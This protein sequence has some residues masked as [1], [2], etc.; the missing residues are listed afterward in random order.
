MNNT[1]KITYNLCGGVC[2][3]PTAYSEDDSF[4]LGVPLR[5]GYRFLGWTSTD[6]PAPQK[7]VALPKGSRGDREYT[8][9][10]E[11]KDRLISD[12][13]IGADDRL[14]PPDSPV[15]LD[16]RKGDRGENI[17]KLKTV[18]T[19][20]EVDGIKDAA[21]DYG[22]HIKSGVYECPEYYKDK[23]IGFDA[24]LTLGQDGYVYVFVEVTDPNV[25]VPDELWHHKNWRCD[26]ICMFLS[27]DNKPV[28]VGV[29]C[30]YAADGRRANTVSDKHAAVRTEKGYNIEFRFNN[31]GSPFV[32]YSG[33]C[34][35]C[36]GI[37]IYMNDCVYFESLD[38]YKKYSITAASALINDG[39]FRSPHGSLMDAVE[40]SYESATGRAMGG[41]AEVF[42]EGECLISSMLSSNSDNAVV[43]SENASVH[44]KDCIRR[45]IC[46][47][48]TVCPRFTT[49]DDRGETADARILFGLTG[50]KESRELVESI[51]YGKCALVFSNGRICVIG[52]TEEAME[53]AT[54]LL[55]AAFEYVSEGGRSDDLCNRYICETDSV[56]V[57]KADGVGVITDAGSGSYLLLCR[58]ADVSAYEKYTEKL[59]D[60]GYSLYA[61]RKFLGSF[62]STYCSDGA[63]VNV[64]FGGEGDRNLRIVAD[65]RKK[66]GLPPVKEQYQARCRPRLIQIGHNSMCYIVKLENGEFIIFD[67]GNNGAEVGIYDTLISQSDDGHPVVAA[68]FFTH[69]HQDHIGGFIDF[70]LKDEYLSRVTVKNVVMNMPAGQVISTSR[71]SPR[72]MMNIELWQSCLERTGC[73]VI[74]PRTGQRFDFGGA[75]IDVLFTFEDVMP[76]F[77]TNDQSNITST[78]FSVNVGGQRIIITGDCEREGT[79]LMADKYRE[80]LKCDF[81]Q[82]PH[83]GYGS[84]GGTVPEFYEY[85]GADYVLYPDERFA[86][87]PTEKVGVDMAKKCFLAGDGTVILDLPFNE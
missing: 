45:F 81:V 64:T 13:N 19:D 69:Y 22:L 65:S 12:P 35:S 30:L 37:A 71:G 31:N 29:G 87:Q 74:F 18:Y 80:G 53:R 60:E 7:R 11:K 83:H 21:Y 25:L 14:T 23:N 49:R 70:A 17:Y 44:T 79:R 77:F 9:L 86:P 46:E 72:D 39:E 43:C 38:D 59:I 41:S 28:H 55:I 48:H 75:E 34:G 66:T 42:G 78:V 40:F 67:S 16:V 52:H 4:T 68:W 24:Y 56:S 27:Y 3:N 1:Y 6:L 36:L 57:P 26:G 54:E 63:I 10:W 85:A 58:D 5:Y 2:S 32:G 33:V 51:P 20:I 61:E 62:C 8:A 15:T 50:E 82:L 73:R 47:M 76:Y 84:G